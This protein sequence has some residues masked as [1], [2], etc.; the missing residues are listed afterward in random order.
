MRLNQFIASS[1]ELSRRGADEAIKD[2]RV[3]I[4]DKAVELGQ[5]VEEGDIVA[6]DGKILELPTR[7]LYVIFNK[8]IGIVVT[9]VHQDASQTIY[10]ILPAKYQSLM[11]VGR[12][13]KDSSGLLLLTND[14]Q[15][16]QRATHPSFEKE[17]TYQIILNRQV[18]A[19]DVAKLEAGVELEDGLSQLSVEEHSGKDLTLIL[20]EGRNRQI[21]R[22]FEA[23]DYCVINLH[24]TQ[25]GP[26]L[27]GDLRPGSCREVD[28]TLL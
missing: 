22:S 2:G 24:R 16:T 21:R 27:L 8:P 18:S 26:Y 13:D 12:L 25:F 19:A 6:L 9:R 14:G 20:S 5:P 3:R 17:K 15:F 10:D 28:G 7:K 11:S 4:N 23:L 1:S